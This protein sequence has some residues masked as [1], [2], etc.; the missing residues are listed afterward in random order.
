MHYYITCWANGTELSRELPWLLLEYPVQD[1]IYLVL[2][3]LFC[4]GS[5][6]RP[7]VLPGALSD[8]GAEYW[9]YVCI[10][11][12]LEQPTRREIPDGSYPEG[13]PHYDGNW[14]GDH[15]NLCNRSHGV[16]DWR[17]NRSPIS[18]ITYFLAA[19]IVDQQRIFQK[20]DGMFC[21]KKHPNI[22]LT[23]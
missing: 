9:R 15:C 6:I 7:H 10:G 12:D 20:R 13:W 22:D 1:L 21:C 16:P 2:S 3:D 19:F 14:S 4:R 5:S 18:K 8:G 23:K 17:F 11:P